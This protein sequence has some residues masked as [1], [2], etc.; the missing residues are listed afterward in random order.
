MK[1][2]ECKK[3]R[4]VKKVGVDKKLISS[5]IKISEDRL[6]VDNYAPLNETTAP[7]KVVNSYESLREILEAVAI[8]RGFKI[9]GH[10]CIAGFIAEVLKMPREANQ[11]NKFRIIRNGVNY[12]GRSVKLLDS[13]VLIKEINEARIKFLKMLNG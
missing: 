13:K 12:Y 3:R 4:F 2:S 1:W 11:F 5:L 8:S 6:D 10:D 7:I 9:Y